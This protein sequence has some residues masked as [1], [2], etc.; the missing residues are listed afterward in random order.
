MGPQIATAAG[1][2][3]R[4]CPT[5]LSPFS[6]KV[7]RQSLFGFCLLALLSPLR[8]EIADQYGSSSSLITR[9]NIGFFAWAFRS[10]PAFPH[11][12]SDACRHGGFRLPSPPIQQSPLFFSEQNI[13]GNGPTRSRRTTQRPGQCIHRIESQNTFYNP[14]FASNNDGERDMPYENGSSDNKKFSMKR[15]GGRRRQQKRQPAAFEKLPPSKNK[16][17]SGTFLV[18]ALLVLNLLKNLFF[19]GI[20]DSSNYYYYSYS[21]SSVYETQINPDGSRTTT[22][23]SRKESSDLKTNIPGLTDKDFLDRSNN[24][25]RVF[26]NYFDFEE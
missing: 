25:D 14:L 18:V 13:H 10:N 9:I 3:V 2:K 19:G 21:S 8:W 6:R 20:N 22:E 12:S 24:R 26:T 23:T 17:P 4:K 1:R 7:A 15:V 16:L 5:T 11:P